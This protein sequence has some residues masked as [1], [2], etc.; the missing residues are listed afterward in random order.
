MTGKAPVDLVL[1]EFSGNRFD[2]RV[3]T[4]L[5]R[6]DGDGTINV[7]DA[8][9]VSR[10]SDGSVEWLE[11][12]NVDKRLAALVGEPA[13][14]LAAEDAE[15]I[16]EELQPDTAIG[17]LLFEHSWASTLSEAIRGVGGNLLDWERVPAAAITE[18]AGN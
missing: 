8:L 13:G 17:M 6:L 7:L 10:G 18:L 2:G 3:L 16:A 11:A 9:L 14:L 12:A 15:A 5:E 1:V 4:E